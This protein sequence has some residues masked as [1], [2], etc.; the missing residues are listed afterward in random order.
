[1]LLHVGL[2]AWRGLGRGSGLQDGSGAIRWRI[3]EK[4]MRAISAAI[5]VLAGAVMFVGVRL[6]PG[7]GSQNYTEMLSCLVGVIGFIAW[8]MFASSD[9]LKPK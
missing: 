6:Q 4:N 1:L 3:K 9:H 7:G 5:I 8:A 2:A